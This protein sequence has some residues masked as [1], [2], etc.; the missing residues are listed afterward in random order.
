[1]M[2]LLVSHGADVNALW[3]GHFPIIFAPCETLD[4]ARSEMA[5]RS[6]RKSELL[7]TMARGQRPSYPGTALDYVIGAYARSPN[8]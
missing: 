6:R 8:G 3:N 7:A 4:P 2:E 5:S 1:M